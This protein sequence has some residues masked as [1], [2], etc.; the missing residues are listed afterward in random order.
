MLSHDDT[1]LIATLKAIPS[2]AEHSFVTAET[3]HPHGGHKEERV[4]LYDLARAGAGGF[5][6]MQPVATFTDHS[7]AI[8]CLATCATPHF[9]V[10][11][12]RGRLPC[13]GW[14]TSLAIPDSAT[15]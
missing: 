5:E 15:S 4:C 8:T 12:L 3:N 14:H 10:H 9:D 13:D 7:D 6:R 2:I 11:P 1:T